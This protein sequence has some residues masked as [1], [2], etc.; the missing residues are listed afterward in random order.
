VTTVSRK[1]L[2]TMLN[3]ASSSAIAFSATQALAQEDVAGSDEEGIREIVVTAQKRAESIQDALLANTVLDSLALDQAGIKDAQGLNG[4]VPNV[5]VR[6]F[7]NSLVVATR[8]I[9]N[10]NTTNLGDA[11]LALHLN[12][13]YLGRPNVTY[14]PT[15]ALNLSGGLCYSEDQKRRSL[16]T[17]NYPGQISLT[18][19]PCIESFRAGT[20][21]TKL[22]APFAINAGPPVAS[23]VIFSNGSNHQEWDSVDWKVGFDWQVAPESLLYASVSTGYRAGGFN[24]NNVAFN[25]EE[26]LAYEVGLKNDLL[27]SRLRLNLAAIYDDYQ[28]LQVTAPSNISGIPRVFT[29]NAASG[30]IWDFEIEATARPA[31]WLTFDATFGYVNARSDDFSS[32]DLVCGL[33]GVV[34][35]GSEPR[36][37]CTPLNQNFKGNTLAHAPDVTVSFGVTAT[38]F[39]DDKGHL[40]AKAAT[41]LVGD[42]YLSESNRL[43]DRIDGYTNSQA[44]LTSETAGGNFSFEAFVQ[45]IEKN[46]VPASLSLTVSGAT[47][48]YNSPRTYEDKLGVKY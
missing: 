28:D 9:S 13:V 25:P 35:V 47:T 31:N 32:R 21:G 44:R 42:S 17:T 1:T 23:N 26:I 5:V 11:S 46:D 12:G 10:E 18:Q 41:R 48:A 14:A 7:N 36:P 8:G 39:D 40:F 19:L 6:L 3:I 20:A 27:G 30:T 29:Q 4:V 15:D 34:F 16:R 24:N 43:I 33:N 38:L 2:R 37:G 22:G 45:N